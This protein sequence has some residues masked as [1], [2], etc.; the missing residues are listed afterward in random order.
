TY[1]DHLDPEYLRYYFA[2]KMSS[3]V[4][5][6][7]INL[8]DFVQ[9]VNS[10]LVGKVVN[11]ASRCSGFINKQFDSTLA[12]RADNPLIAEFQQAGETIA[13]HYENGDFG[14]AMRE[15]MSLADKA[16]QYIAENQ[17]W[18][19][20]KE[21]GRQ[22][23][24]H[25]ICSDGLNLFRIL[26]IYL[27]PVL[28]GLAEKAESFFDVA[29]LTWD[30]AATALT[31]HN[32]RKFK[33]MLTRVE[34]EKVDAIVN[35]TKTGEPGPQQEQAKP[36]TEADPD[37]GLIQFDDFA[38]VDLR[39]ARIVSAEHVDGADKLLRLVLDLG[40]ETR[41]VFAGIKAAYEDPAALEGRLTVM[42][43][44]L[45]PRKMKFGVSEGMV[46]AAGPGGK[47]VFLLQPDAGA[48]PGMQVC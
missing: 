28:P 22:Q 36:A 45:A 21:D 35:D 1:L 11:I 9:R 43:A 10:D 20:I 46:L 29:P 33:P 19:L 2:A 30:D 14:K 26:V 3:G 4:D 41:Q 23:E 39:V 44:N 27:K 16:N 18:V 24:V 48:E 25:Q 38:R 8:E 7:D 47:E 5:D 42:V 37:T 31:G 13:A 40:G 32:I 17:P 34:M 15:I 6:L 12:D